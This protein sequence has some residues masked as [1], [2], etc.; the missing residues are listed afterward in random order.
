MF[1]PTQQNGVR[2]ALLRGTDGIHE[3]TVNMDNTA[4]C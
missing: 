1:I 2:F 4:S 3:T